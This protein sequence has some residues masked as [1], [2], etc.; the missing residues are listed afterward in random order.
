MEADRRQGYRRILVTRLRFIG[1][2]VLTTPILR[3]IRQAYPDAFIAYLGDR[4]AVRLLEHHPCVDQ[5]LPYDFTRADLC[6]QVRAVRTIRRHRFDLVIDLFGNPRSALLTL[7][8]GAPVRVGPDRKGRGRAYTNRV[9]DDGRTKTAIEYHNQALRAAGIV[10]TATRTEVILT[11]QEQNAGRTALALTLGLAPERLTSTPVVGIHPGAS[12]P[13]KRWLPERYAKLADRLRDEAGAAVVF[14]AGP[15]DGDVIAAVQ[16]S[17]SH[18][19]P[20]LAGLP[21]RD[22]ASVI[23]SCTVY[24]SNDAGP[25]HIAPA[26][27]T[28]TIGIFGPGEEEIWFPYTPDE[29][30]RALRNTVPC[31]PCHLDFCT[32]QGGGYMECMK[33]LTVDEVFGVV[34]RRIERFRRD[35]SH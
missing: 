18:S 35:V 25:M 28:P 26:V 19:I 3:S 7:L 6:E 11:E 2:I 33:L 15:N 20:V 21:L 5:I 14:T 13:A 1:D 34:M 30:H 17:V 27:G 4:T 23:A 32:R 31:H 8:S 16:S 29:G 22:L 10:P 24:V 12:W 9:R